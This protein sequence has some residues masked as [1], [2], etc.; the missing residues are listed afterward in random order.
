MKYTKE[1]EWIKYDDTTHEAFIGI[2][3]HAQSELGDI[4]HVEF[5]EPGDLSIGDALCTIESVKSTSE[6]FIPFN[7]THLESNKAVLDDVSQINQ[8]AEGTW[9]HKVKVSDPGVINV[10]LTKEEYL[11][12]L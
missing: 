9:L 11:K 12:S 5:N 6:V 10:L 2:T 1:H 8:N 3:D 4:V 7:G